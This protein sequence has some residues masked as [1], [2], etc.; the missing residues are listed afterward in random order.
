M[1]AVNH[2]EQEYI[3]VRQKENRLYTDGQVKLLPEI[4]ESHPH[5][6]EWQ[7]RKSSCN[8]LVGYL[9][10]K[11]KKL[12]ILE[13]GCGNGWL[14][15]H[16]SKIANSKVTGIDINKT[17]LEQ[18]K[19]VFDQIEN[20]HFFHGEIVNE[21]TRN[22]K[23]DT[24]IFA[25]S[26]QHF[27]SLDEILSLA[28]QLL[29]PLGEIHILDSHFYRPLEVEAARR[30]SV[31]YYQSMKFPGMTKYYFHHCINELK[32]YNYKILYNPGSIFNGFIKNKNPFHWITVSQHA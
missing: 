9:T 17:E 26:I 1:L 22:Q 12:N 21:N 24:I 8:K 14:C 30:R 23:F 10:H 11:R 18:A 27:P 7:I 2:F 28:T 3:S 15:S 4:E 20:L 13:V 5:Y 6:K 19:R 29:N 25:A 16:L 31:D 32:P